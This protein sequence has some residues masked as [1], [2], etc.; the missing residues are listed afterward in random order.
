[1]RI[2][3]QIAR[4][5]LIGLVLLSWF[6]P[7]QVWASE[8]IPAQPEPP[9]EVQRYGKLELVSQVGGTVTDTI[10]Q[11]SFA[12]IGK[13]ARLVILDIADPAQPKVAGASSEMP[14]IVQGL[15]VNAQYAYIADGGGGLRVLNI[16]D[17]SNIY[18]TGFYNT[19]A[20]SVALA[21]PQSAAKDGKTFAYVADGD[22]KVIDVSDPA[23]PL[24]AAALATPGR[25]TALAVAGNLLYLADGDSGLQVVDISNPNQPLIQFS[26]ALPGFTYGITYE[27]RDG[28]HLVY[29]ANGEIGGL[30]IIDV[31]D[32][33][34]PVEVGS[35]DTG[36]D[37]REVAVAQSRA[38]LANGA[39]GLA[40]I[41]VTDPSQ[42]S[43]L[44]AYDSPGYAMGVAVK[45]NIA[46]LA[47]GAALITVDI[48]DPVNPQKAGSYD[49]LGAAYGVALAQKTLEGKLRTFAYVADYY[50]GMYVM[51]VS[52]KKLRPTVISFYNTP[53]F[54]DRITLFSRPESGSTA[55]A[56]TLNAVADAKTY[57]YISSPLDGV[58]VVDV[59]SPYYP[60]DAG[61]V[62]T[63][64]WAH[65]ASLTV[66]PDSVTTDATSGRVYAYVA[67]GEQGGLR[68]LDLSQ[69]KQP[70][71]T[72]FYKTPGGARGVAVASVSLKT[73]RS[74]D[75][76]ELRLISA[77]SPDSQE[78]TFAYVADG[79]SGLQVIDVS[80]PAYPVLAGALDTPV[81][82]EN[83]VLSGKY[84][85][86][87]DGQNGGL[88]VIDVHDPYKPVEVGAYDVQGYAGNLTVQDT[89]VYLADGDGGLRVVDVSDPAHP[90]E[91]GSYNMPGYT[92]DVAVWEDSVYVANRASGLVVLR[93]I[94]P[95]PLSLKVNS[96]LDEQ[97]AVPGDGL[98]ETRK[99]ECTLRAAIQE[100]NANVGYD[101]ITLPAGTYTLALSGQGEDHAASG[102]LDIND[103]V[104][105]S[106]ENY[107]TTIIDGG[108]L[109]RVLHI[110]SSDKRLWVTLTN[111]T[112]QNGLG[113]INVQH[114]EDFSL[115]NSLI[116]NNAG[117]GLWA[118]DSQ[119]L[120][121]GCLVAGNSDSQYVGGI[122]SNLGKI[123]IKNTTVAN[124]SGTVGGIS[125]D[126]NLVLVNT[127]VSGNK[128]TSGAGGVRVNGE[129]KFYNSTIS[130]NAG[131]SVGG[132]EAQAGASTVLTNT[133]V[134]GN[135]SQSHAQD[136]SGRIVSQGNNLIGN[137][138]G[139]VLERAAGDQLGIDARLAP[140]GALDT[141][142]AVHTL[143]PGSPALDGGN[144]QGCRDEDGSPLTSDQLGSPRPQNGSSIC[145]S[146]AVEAVVNTQHP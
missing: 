141:L 47:D 97:D 87:A 14:D 123:V 38:Y 76:G 52:D 33:Q 6:I 2:F 16:A 131:M 98:C 40:V 22:L 128:A 55:A 85:Y 49:V 127:T 68:I 71:E 112:I 107:K 121:S 27:E 1:M 73:A 144:P 126:G 65:A 8:G 109:D 120:L 101:K 21:A 9:V 56:S 92:S 39:K 7:H 61:T 125:V 80:D 5:G 43:L 142:A 140:L 136:C 106:G 130:A 64:G 63:P 28:K 34:K 20:S 4:F 94:Q 57:A 132:I 111:L 89:R 83:V 35:L 72:G 25:A 62:D 81:F 18:E 102:D 10:V 46:Y 31:S 96:T 143:L 82:A 79:A 110:I 54:A 93:F 58:S 36:G 29:L 133:I 42:P 59:T 117:Y 51:D 23:N 26:M 145:D 105:L 11:D 113:G 77:S 70:V 69:P 114:A 30:H 129:G 75:Q 84:A 60:V 95:K 146:G 45:D 13:G 116:T 32:P 115:Y 124:N 41:N 100:T 90:F 48:Q 53:G 108:G 118:S 12:Y 15:A 104:M 137:P 139:F 19:W 103:H 67:D 37:M 99:K 50:D 135:T 44:G 86:V 17:P 74:T 119:V 3:D 122:G 24:E 88:R 134:A 78:K 91:V 138:V 66:L